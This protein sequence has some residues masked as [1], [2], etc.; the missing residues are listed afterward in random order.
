M[1]IGGAR[2]LTRQCATHRH[3]IHREPGRMSE[4]V[5]YLVWAMFAVCGFGLGR[6]R[7]RSKVMVVPDVASLPVTAPWSGSGPAP[8]RVVTLAGEVRYEGERGGLA[9]RHIEALRAERIE[10]R[11][12][13]DGMVWD[14]GPR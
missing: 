6:F 14:W 2:D 10:W 9:R 13:R 3:E 4:Y 12:Y 7:R 11:A 1:C 5:E 8:F